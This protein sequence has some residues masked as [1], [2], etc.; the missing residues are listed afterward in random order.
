M[1]K[2]ADGESDGDAEAEAAKKAQANAKAKAKAKVKASKQGSSSGTTGG[3]ADE[4]EDVI[5]QDHPKL[6][7]NQPAQL[8]H[9]NSTEAELA[10]QRLGYAFVN[11]LDPEV[12]HWSMD[13]DD[14]RL[15]RGALFAES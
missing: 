12:S 4:D 7:T 8:S 9:D 11:L 1:D 13:G 15:A 10:K 5:V 2:D 3:P 14:A 6:W